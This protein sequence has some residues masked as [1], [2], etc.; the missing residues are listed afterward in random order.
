MSRKFFHHDVLA[1][2]IEMP[3]SAAMVSFAIWWGTSTISFLTDCQISKGCR[4]A[5]SLLAK[6][7][8]LNRSYWSP[9]GTLSSML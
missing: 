2:G 9:A 3:R 4:G 8:G 6:S 5:A 1:D 7:A